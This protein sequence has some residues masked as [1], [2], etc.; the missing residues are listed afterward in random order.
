MEANSAVTDRVELGDG[1]AVLIGPL[2]PSDRERW[3]RGVRRASAEALFKRFMSP[4]DRLTSSQIAYL[5]GVDHRDHEA[6]LAVDEDSGEAV[7][8]GRFVRSTEDP[9]RAEAAVLVVDE[10]QG[11][12]LGKAMARAL[13]DRA[14]ALGIDRF[15]ATMLPGNKP[16][17]AVLDWLGEIHNLGNDGGTLNVEIVLP[18][19]EPAE[20]RP[21]ALRTAD[22]EGYELAS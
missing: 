5:V 18:D 17:L 19:P 8:V 3:L 14:R 20:R 7:A 21:G 4:V 16:M 9:T 10:W 22:G 2:H 12:G 1:R 13:S 6:L 15:E 11:R